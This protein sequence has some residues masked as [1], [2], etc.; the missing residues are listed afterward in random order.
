[1]SHTECV[2]PGCLADGSNGLPSQ[3]IDGFS[4][5]SVVMWSSILDPAMGA[6]SGQEVDRRKEMY[7]SKILLGVN[8]FNAKSE[9]SPSSSDNGAAGEF[10]F[11]IETVYI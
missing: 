5:Q 8:S 3:F 11:N 1:M 7:S 9:L 4:C 2:P 6:M 10:G